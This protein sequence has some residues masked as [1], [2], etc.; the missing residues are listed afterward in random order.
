MKSRAVYNFRKSQK[1][2]NR[3]AKAE[4]LRTMTR[5]QC[6]LASAVLLLTPY[7]CG[8]ATESSITSQMQKLR[9]LSAE[10][11]P[12]AT[13]KVAHDIATLPPGLHKVQ[14]ADSVAHLVTEGDQGQDALQAVADTLAKSLAETPV[15]P[16]RDE[17]PMPYSDLARLVRYSSV[18]A[19]LSDPLYAKATAQLDA[20]E[21]DIAKADFTLKDLHNKKWTLSQLRGKIVL[22]NFWATWCPPCRVE[23]PD[24]D[25]IY[26]HYQ[27]QM[28]VVSI[29]DEDAFK[30][31]SF[32][33]PMGYHPPVLLDPGGSIH[34][35]FHVVG[36]P[37]TYV[38]DRDGKLVS[39]AMDQR[40]QRQFFGML[41]NA[42]LQPR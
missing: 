40:T 27:S 30:V 31:S 12:A 32:I 35:M 3:F 41:A 13:I 20:N 29:T 26:T 38:F 39:V 18:T 37:E 34:K 22:V 15:P 14:F 17:V 24:L 36:L 28:V 5:S 6:I 10:Q 23:M 1:H 16:K 4:V 33:S 42:G 9:S 2:I 8:Q 19:T 21:A 25:A 11:R 7:L